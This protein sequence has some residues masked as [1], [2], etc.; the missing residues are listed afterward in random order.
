MTYQENPMSLSS[1][2]EDM[3][4]VEEVNQRESSETR[5]LQKLRALTGRTESLEVLSD[6]LFAENQEEAAHNRNKIEKN[7]RL[8]KILGERPHETSSSLSLSSSSR[9]SDDSARIQKV[10]K[11]KQITGRTQSVEHIGNYI[12]SHTV[13]E[14]IENGKLIERSDKLKS[15][16]GKRPSHQQM[17][18]SVA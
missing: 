18:T 17:M 14:A 1:S 5:R 15:L 13:E 6:C 8:K 7:D 12:M 2:L 9:T 16:F 3:E 4:D 11:L 10:T